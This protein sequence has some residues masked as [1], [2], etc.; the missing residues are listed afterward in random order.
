MIAI[1]ELLSKMRTAL[2][3]IMKPDLSSLEVPPVPDLN[4]F[5][6]T[7]GTN[8]ID[9]DRAISIDIDN[10]SGGLEVTICTFLDF[11]VEGQLSADGLLDN[12]E[13]SI[14]LIHLMPGML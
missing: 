9:N 13:E 6:L 8:C 10:P 1:S 12:L 14:S 11:E 2:S 5:Q 7:P 3:S 4:T